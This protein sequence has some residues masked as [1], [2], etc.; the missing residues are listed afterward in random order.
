MT[1]KASFQTALAVLLAA[2]LIAGG[3]LVPGLL[4]G[5]QER[6]LLSTSGAVAADSLTPYARKTLAERV[7]ALSRTLLDTGTP[8][9]YLHDAREPLGTELTAAQAADAANRFLQTLDAVHG[10]SAAEQ[11]T[12]DTDADASLWTLGDDPSVALWVFEQPR[13][14]VMLD[15]ASGVP[16]HFCLTAAQPKTPPM[17][18]EEMD[19]LVWTVFWETYQDLYGDLFTLDFDYASETLG[20]R[21]GSVRTLRSVRSAAAYSLQVRIR[22]NSDGLLTGLESS[23]LAQ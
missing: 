22:M 11:T 23:I 3:L 7:A 19:E 20:T 14:T 2:A 21:E 5:R 16:V 17:M 12:A 6:S 10:I 13:C 1:N 15:A 18:P 8:S 9:G 4:L